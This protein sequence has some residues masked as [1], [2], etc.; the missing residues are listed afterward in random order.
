[1]GEI[2]RLL[3]DA[4]MV[5]AL[6]LSTWFPP[7]CKGAD[8]DEGFSSEERT[9]VDEAPDRFKKFVLPH[10]ISTGGARW[11]DNDR[12]IMTVS[13]LPNGWRAE[14]GPA[15]TAPL[16]P[17]SDLPHGMR[18]MIVVD[19]NTGAI[20]DSPYPGQIV[21]SDDGR[22]VIELPIKTSPGSAWFAGPFGQALTAVP[23]PAGR[24]PR[25]INAGCAVMHKD[26]DSLYYPLRPEDG[27]LRV[28]LP[29][30]VW[31]DTELSAQ[32]L[33]SSGRVRAAFTC[34]ADAL[35]GGVRFLHFSG[36]YAFEN[37]FGPRRRHAGG[38]LSKDGSFTAIEP[39]PFLFKLAVADG[40][41]G[42]LTFTR[43]GPLWNYQ[44]SP[45]KWRKQGLYLREDG[46]LLRLEDKAIG[47]ITV[48]PDGCRVFYDRSNGDP[49]HDSGN[50]ASQRN[51][52]QLVLTLC[53]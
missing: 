37:I 21:C 44:S 29:P 53:S 32:V 30:M 5:G 14:K 27:T 52:D 3:R 28:S 36:Q 50:A 25:F 16:S 10:L 8:T 48:S 23:A 51:R 22:V 47:S 39:D 19:A 1:M 45:S 34:T 18:R 11:L 49:N 9:Q 15:P 38:L 40:G 12:L 33:A 17:L 2:G 26:A 24:S 43:K 42:S 46:K 41:V 4:G 6:V 20:S 13:E 35:P 7:P 31:P